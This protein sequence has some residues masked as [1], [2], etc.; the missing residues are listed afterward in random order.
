M[1]TRGRSTQ[2]GITKDRHISIIRMKLQVC[3]F[4]E[5]HL[6]R[7][8]FFH[9]RSWN[10]PDADFTHATLLLECCN[11]VSHTPRSLPFG[12]EVNDD[13]Q[14][15]PDVQHLQWSVWGAKN[16]WGQA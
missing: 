8:E 5:W 1:E 12:P 4:R 15:W 14:R 13:R 11:D 7:R 16:S 2:E 10:A 6:H 3:Q 9:Q